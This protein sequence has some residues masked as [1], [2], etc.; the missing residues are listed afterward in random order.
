MAGGADGEKSQAA[1]RL[2]QVITTRGKKVAE[3]CRKGVVFCGPR[4][5]TRGRATVQWTVN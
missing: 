1:G 5:A 4:I 2:Q 3:G